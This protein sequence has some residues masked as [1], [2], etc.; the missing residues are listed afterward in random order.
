MLFR[1]QLKI[2]ASIDSVVLALMPLPLLLLWLEYHK[3]VLTDFSELKLFSVCTPYLNNWRWF[4]QCTLVADEGHVGTPYQRNLWQ[5]IVSIAKLEW[6]EFI[7]LYLRIN[8]SL[9]LLRRQH[10]LRRDDRT[11]QE[12]TQDANHSTAVSCRYNLQDVL[13]AVHLIDTFGIII[14]C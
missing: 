14:I 6:A 9:K 5:T 12:F 8:F 3:T 11:E 2:L 7:W 1:T 13:T 4:Q 10:L